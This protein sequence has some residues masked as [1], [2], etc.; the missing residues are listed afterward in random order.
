MWKYKCKFCLVKKDEGSD[1]RIS[2]LQYQEF[3]F[4]YSLTVPYIQTINEY[5]A[6]HP[7]YVDTNA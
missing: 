5:H 4:M 1:I 6:L 7:R 3:G 2:A